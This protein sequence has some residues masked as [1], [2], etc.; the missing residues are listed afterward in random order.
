MQMAGM[1][2]VVLHIPH[3]DGG[4]G[5]TFNDIA[6]DAA[7]YTT[8]SCFVARL[9]A[10]TQERQGLWLPKDDLKNASSW[11]SSPLVLLRDIHSDLLVKYDCEDSAPPQLFLGRGLVLGAIPKMVYLSRRLLP[12]FFHSLTA[13]ERLTCGERTLPML[14]PSRPRI[15]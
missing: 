3:A 11:S 5:V 4:F 13:S 9:G 10:F 7:F 12:S 2:L 1:P 14:P 15:G 6:K 8:T